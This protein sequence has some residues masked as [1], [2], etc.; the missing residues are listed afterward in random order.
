M[1]KPKQRLNRRTF[2]TTG[3]LALAAKR[4]SRAEESS[5]QI[6]TAI[7]TICCDGFGDEDF[8]YAFESIPQLGIKN[9]E[10]NCWF[11]RN[12]T[13]SGLKSIRER[14][15]IAKLSPISIQ[16][17]GFGGG[18]NHDRAKEVARLL[19][20]LQACA[21]IGCHLIKCT[22]ARRGQAGGL[23]S[24]VAVLSAVAPEAERRGVRIALENHHGNVIEF[25]EDY[26][27]L[28][29][30]IPSKAIGMCFDMGHFA[31]SGVAM[32]PLIEEMHDRI[33]EID[34]KDA[35]AIGG[36]KFVRFGTGIVDCEGVI[37]EC[38]Q[39]GY[40]GY[41]TLELS[42]IDRDTMLEDLRAGLAITR[43]FERI[44]G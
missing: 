9:V 35:D 14:C 20:L 2:A 11:A 4:L 17:S 43:P 32:T 10:F 29:R 13:P 21:R 15:D 37:G 12:L 39:R 24:L 25:P 41:L 28:F 30:K 8:K 6:Q 18:S 26:N 36:N 40:S 34:V 1:I 38:V 42:L 7:A 44:S 5:G 3:A 31:R 16:A 19:W 22:G 23:D 33:Y 27:F